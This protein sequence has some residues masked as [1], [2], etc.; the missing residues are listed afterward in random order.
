[1]ALD[2]EIQRWADNAVLDNR[3]LRLIGIQIDTINKKNARLPAPWLITP[4]KDPDTKD[5]LLG[6]EVN[7]LTPGKLKDRKQRIYE[8]AQSMFFDKEEET[9]Q[10]P[11]THLQSFVLAKD[12]D[13][14]LFYLM[15]THPE[16]TA[17]SKAKVNTLI[18]RFYIEDKAREMRDQRSRITEKV[19]AFELL[20]AIPLEDLPGYFRIITDV[21]PAE[22]MSEDM[23][24]GEIE[25]KADESPGKILQ[26]LQDPEVRSNVFAAKLLNKS[27]IAYEKTTGIYR[28]GSTKIAVGFRGLI[29]Y[30]NDESNSLI[31]SQWAKEVGDKVFGGTGTGK[32][33]KKILKTE[34][35][36]TSDESEP[37][38]PA[39]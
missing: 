12:F 36:D 7:A 15:L 11:L 26:I 8:K 33:K 28:H 1:M 34:P 9:L 19:K 18:H 16:V 21:K 5:Y 3:V 13:A 4:R 39:E 14:A 32:S 23:L 27:V 17:P 2:T 37:N 35:A 22:Y 6:C 30:I 25:M 24:L 38:P 20:K 29:D 10:F 31:I